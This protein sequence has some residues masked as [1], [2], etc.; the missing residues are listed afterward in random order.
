M[1]TLSELTGAGGDNII[2]G[3]RLSELRAIDLADAE[4]EASREYIRTIAEGVAN[5]E[6]PI[7]E[8]FIARAVDNL[9][10]SPFLYGSPWFR[11][12][13]LS[14]RGTFYLAYL[15]LRITEP[16]IAPGEAARLC[17]EA[18]DAAAAWLWDSLRW[19]ESKNAV[20][21]T[22]TSQSSGGQSGSGSPNPPPA[23][24]ATAM[25]TPAA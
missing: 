22:R 25:T 8:M 19:R 2:V 7:Q 12:W 24:S 23:D 18:G 1:P 13:G 3:H 11:A 16:R 20:P 6:K 4:A 10:G 15:S 21:P 14:W 5:L 17:S 9:K